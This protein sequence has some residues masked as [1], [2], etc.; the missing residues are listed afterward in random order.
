MSRCAQAL[1]ITTLAVLA[2]AL[3]GCPTAGAP[4]LAV[5]PPALS[6]GSANNSATF[7]IRNTGGGVLSYAASSNAP[8]LLLRAPGAAAASNAISGTTADI[9]FIEIQID[10]ALLPSKAA[11]LGIVE[12]S[13]AGASAEVRVSVA[14]AATPQLSPSAQELDFGADLSELELVLSNTGQQNIDWTAQIPDTAPWLS[15]SPASGALAPGAFA[16][17][18]IRAGRA[19]LPPG[20]AEATL[21]IESN[22][23]TIEIPV[24]IEAPVLEVSPGAIAFGLIENEATAQIQVENRSFDPVDITVS[25]AAA[26]GAAWLQALPASATLPFDTP[27]A[28][29]VRANPAGLAPGSY[30]GTVTIAS[31][32]PAFT[33]EIP[34][35]MRLSGFR[36][37]P[38]SLDFG[39][40]Q[41]PAQQTV[42]LTNDAPAPLDFTATIPLDARQWLSAEP[43]TGTIDDALNFVVSVDPTAV[44]PGAL[45]QSEIVF[46]H[47]GLEDRL[48]VRMQVPLPPALAVSPRTLDFGA[49][50]IELPLAIW[51]SGIGTLDWEI[52]TAGFPAWLSLLPVGAD[53]RA[54]G[55]VSGDLTDKLD[56]RVDRAQV[57]QGP[58]QFQHQFTV[59]ATGDVTA[60]V[61]VTVRLTVP[62]IPQIEVE[63][64][65]IDSTGRPFINFDVEEVQET[66][67]IRN[68]GNG[69]LDWRIPT[70]DRPPW[71]VS[72]TPSQGS[73]EPNREQTITVTVNRAGLTFLGAQ[74][75]LRI[76]S[77]DP[78][79]PDI[80]LIVEIQVPKRPRVGVRPSSLAFG[81]N[82]TS[83]VVEVANLGDPDTIL[84]FRITPSKDWVSAFPDTG[85]SIG[86]DLDIK[87]WRPVSVSIDRTRLDGAGASARLT[88]TPF[89]IV[90]GQ[91]APIPGLEPR[92]IEISVE[93]P[94]LTIQSAPP[95]LRVPSLVR[96]HMLMRNLLQQPIQLPESFL[97]TLNSN[98]NIF[99]QDLPLD[100][101]ESAQFM[102][103]PDRLRNSVLVLL[104]YSGSMLEAARAVQDPDIALA[105]DPVTALYARCVLPLIDALPDNYEIALAIFNER[106][107]GPPNPLV[108]V[109]PVRVLREDASAPVFTNDRDL[110]RA[111]FNSIDVVDFGATQ[112]LQALE[113]AARA[114][115]IYDFEQKRIPFDDRDVKAVIC[116]TDGRTTTP[117]FI[118]VP[119]LAEFFASLRVRLL[120]VGWGEDV[121]KDPLI[122]IAQ[123]TGG[124]FYPTLSEPTGAFDPFG[125]PIQAPV[126][127]ELIKWFDTNPADPCDQ[128]IAQDLASI[129]TLNYVT[130]TDEANVTLDARVT[131]NDPTDQNSPCI[132]E[133]GDISA[134][135]IHRQLPFNDFIGDVRLGQVALSSEGINGGTAVIQARA[136]YIPR[137]ISRLAF[138]I[139]L[140]SP[141]PLGLSVEAV[142]T[143]SGGLLDGWVDS[144]ALPV[145]TYTAPDGATLR[146]GDYGGLVNITVTGATQPFDVLFEVVDPV[147]DAAAPES[148]YFSAPDTFTVTAGPEF[149]PSFPS[150]RIVS[151]PEF[152]EGPGNPFARDPFFLNL[153]DDDDG[154]VISIFNIGGHHAPTG[155]RLQWNA[156][157][158]GGGISL[159]PAAFGSVTTNTGVSTLPVSVDRTQS[160]GVYT[161]TVTIEYLLGSLGVALPPDEI[162]IT[163]AVQPPQLAVDPDELDFGAALNELPLAVINEGQSTLDW[164][165]N[166]AVIP[167]WI[168]VTSES[169]SLAQDER[170][171]FLVRVNRDLAPQ[172]G[173]NTYNLVISGNGQQRTVTIRAEVP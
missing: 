118:T 88:V 37:A 112:L 6:I 10:R 3:A 145:Y 161:G 170:S 21:R 172:S 165:I 49:T 2:G 130:L 22:A 87:D 127:D 33:R 61:E 1:A 105:P 95:S 70:G 62:L 141:E 144:V 162:Q 153:A 32:A 47:D 45:Y 106:T 139:Q 83:R 96:T 155:V 28:I 64:E 150:P 30:A 123:T 73:L 113:D 12:V 119:E 111:R 117:S 43:Q 149:A 81:P 72:I 168:T 60:N 148:K 8:W 133:Q 38:Q 48:P 50:A 51:N 67:I 126:A 132:T 16:T 36:F 104:D 121:A 109:S 91:P 146:Y 138:R 98:F 154:A 103:G 34:V 23:G 5:E 27:L 131:F 59:T 163:Y 94:Q 102:T 164:F 173:V 75:T 14:A 20:A 100:L 52:D 76:L 53:G 78:D 77:N 54:S 169:G 63:A 125:L 156:S 101:A 135:V 97:P 71:I 13:G 151:V 159:P 114:T 89:R 107:S 93:V 160:P 86:N 140:D 17:L 136:D 24:R 74:H 115:F 39:S 166:A 69:V 134:S 137:N 15:S 92:D 128:S 4:R 46:T 157:S 79:F 44:A 19:L 122:R 158:T 9:A 29:E 58:T 7:R 42:Q 65:G 56:V 35:T 143:A 55:T 124:H 142:R 66:L 40:I 110:A 152:S 26:D 147:I 108:P 31:E 41:E 82:D 84:N 80:P 85:Q 90:D 171:E 57:P 18:R 129:V 120:A 68:R 11:A 99:E 25:A 116:I 167:Q